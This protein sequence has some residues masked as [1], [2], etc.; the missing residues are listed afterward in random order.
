M[1]DERTERLINRRL[2]GQLTEDE[3]LELNKLLI[4]SPEAQTLL[5]QYAAMDEQ[6]G[7]VVRTVVSAP[8]ATV[9]PG[10]VSGWSLAPRRWWYSFGLISALAA[11]ITLA[12]L[13]SQRVSGIPGGDL[14]ARSVVD[15]SLAGRE[16]FSGNEPD[17]VATIEGPRRQTE[18]LQ[19]EVIGVWDRQSHSLYLLE[20]DSAR[21][22]V[23]P[24]RV[25][26]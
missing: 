13:V 11:A 12:V 15:A 25:N 10:E 3:S 21:S 14:Q 16:F 6:L 7:D 26:Y 9:E 2:D 20:V 24:V 8:A 5:A 4:R 1:I 23:E 17:Y 22:L 18:R 19:R